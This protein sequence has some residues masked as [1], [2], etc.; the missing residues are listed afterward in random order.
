MPSSLLSNVLPSLFGGAIAELITLPMNTI[1]TVYQCNKNTTY[2][3][4][5]KDLVKNGNY[6]RLYNSSIA[7]VLEKSIGISSRFTIYSIL[8]DA[9]G[10]KQNDI[11]SNFING[12]ISGVLS[13]VISHPLDV[14]KTRLQ[15]GSNLNSPRDWRTGYYSGFS[16]A[17]AR[18][19]TASTLMFPIYDY[20]FWYSGNIFISTSLTSLILTVIVHPLDFMKIRQ[21]NG[22]KIELASCYRGLLIN[23]VRSNMH[24]GI[25]MFLTEYLKRSM[26][27]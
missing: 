27:R 17:L 26:Y 1:K 25:M 21:I 16:K 4:T 3:S 10:T 5:Y 7:S 13:L 18:N 9:R 14:V 23:I 6:S 11:F 19:L 8:K 22:V 15:N 20:C 24:F 12:S 2:T